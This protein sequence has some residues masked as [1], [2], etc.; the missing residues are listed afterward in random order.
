MLLADRVQAA[1]KHLR[2]L[3]GLAEYFDLLRGV[4]GLMQDGVEVSALLEKLQ[5]FT[6][7]KHPEFPREAYKE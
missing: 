6:Y 4:R 5:R 3:P 7:Q 2:P 1:G